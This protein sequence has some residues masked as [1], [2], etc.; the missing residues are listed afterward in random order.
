[1][2][3]VFGKVIDLTEDKFENDLDLPALA[4]D[5][6]AGILDF[7]FTPSALSFLG[8]TL[9]ISLIFDINDEAPTFSFSKT[10]SLSSLTLDL[11]LL[12]TG[13]EGRGGV[14]AGR[15]GCADRGVT[16]FEEGTFLGE[17]GTEGC[18]V[19][20]DAGMGDWNDF[21]DAGRG[22]FEVVLGEADRCTGGLDCWDVIVVLGDEGLG[23]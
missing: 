3:L 14:E 12:S 2:A 19:L 22:E 23:G 21:G 10:S 18:A 1:M 13:D 16:G 4:K 17:A 6:G 5:F 11:D 7:C 15:G 20:G 9:M 8:F